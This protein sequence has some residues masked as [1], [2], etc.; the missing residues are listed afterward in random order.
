MRAKCY[1]C[2]SELHLQLERAVHQLEYS[3]RVVQQA[4][5]HPFLLLALLG[6]T[7]SSCRTDDGKRLPRSYVGCL[8]VKEDLLPDL[9]LPYLVLEGPEVMKQR[10]QQ[11]FESLSLMGCAAR[12]RAMTVPHSLEVRVQP[13]EATLVAVVLREASLKVGGAGC[14]MVRPK[15][16]E[17]VWRTGCSQETQDEKKLPH[18][19]HSE[20][21]EVVGLGED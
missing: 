20:A 15:V 19:G 1:S 18:E 8:L 3:R 9:L 2:S 10:Q 7:Y 13:E 12:V 14:M 17:V 6:L 5:G 21:E 11:P 16:A 4:F